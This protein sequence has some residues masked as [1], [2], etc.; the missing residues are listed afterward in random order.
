MVG[1]STDMGGSIPPNNSATSTC[2]CTGGA[3]TMGG[4]SYTYFG[5]FTGTQAINFNVTSAVRPHY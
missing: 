2:S 3:C 4:W 1:S 5:D